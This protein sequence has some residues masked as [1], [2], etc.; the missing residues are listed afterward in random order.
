MHIKHLRKFSKSKHL[1]HHNTA[2]NNDDDDDDNYTIIIKYLF[3]V[4]YSISSQQ[5]AEV[6]QCFQEHH[7]V[8]CVLIITIHCI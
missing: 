6:A 7:K 3:M 5:T 4:L 8:V 1:K 2:H